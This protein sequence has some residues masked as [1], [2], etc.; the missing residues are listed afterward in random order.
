MKNLEYDDI[1]SIFHD[2]DSKLL[3]KHLPKLMKSFR[4]KESILFWEKM[5][6]NYLNCLYNRGTSGAG[7]KIANKMVGWFTG[8]KKKI[9]IFLFCFCVITITSS[10]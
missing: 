1:V 8:N 6:A 3:A 2:L 7:Y 10:P 4:S 9:Y 5:G